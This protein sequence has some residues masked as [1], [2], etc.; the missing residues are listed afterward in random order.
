MAVYPA[1]NPGAYP[2]DGSTLI[3]QFRNTYGD[4]L[5]EPYDPPVAGFRN[6]AE[7]S[8]DE[9][10]TFLLLGDQSVNKAIGRLYLA[11]AGR[12]AKESLS[13]KDYDLQVDL[14]KRAAD[15]RETA[16]VWFDLADQEGAAED[17]FDIVAVGPGCEAIPEGSPVQFGRRYTMGRVC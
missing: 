11:M 2:V 15:L 7:L 16:R 14:T 10:E 5:S 4:A 9:I 1:G 13:V 8:D 3:G 12:A 17:A 6:Y